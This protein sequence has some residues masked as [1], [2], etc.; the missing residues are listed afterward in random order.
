[1]TDSPLDT[2]LHTLARSG[3]GAADDGTRRALAD[4]LDILGACVLCDR[5][6]RDEELVE[7]AHCAQVLARHLAPE[8]VIS[9]K[10]VR[11]WFAA[12][13]ERLSEF[14]CD[15]DAMRARLSAIE[16][17]DLRRLMLDAIYDI[18][19]CDY[20]LADEEGAVIAAALEVWAP[21]AL[22]PGRLPRLEA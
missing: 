15:A 22:D 1:M 17:P 12:E 6:E 8:A 3:L 7:L 13:R 10:G 16:D 18:S 9:R 5:V 14:A 2:P 19:V 11:D 21:I 20:H 4:A